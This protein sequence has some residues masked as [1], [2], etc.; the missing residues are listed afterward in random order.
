[1]ATTKAYLAHPDYA[2]GQK[3]FVDF[4]RITGF[5]K[6]YVGFMNMQAA[7]AERL[8]GQ[9]VQSLAVYYAPTP[10]SQDVSAMFIRSWADVPEVVTLVQHTE[11][12]ALALLGQPEKSV[13]ELLETLVK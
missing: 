12:E 13:K 8:A 9:N 3:Q 1:L 2:A 4:S 6:D 11:A 10:V 5:E 7:K